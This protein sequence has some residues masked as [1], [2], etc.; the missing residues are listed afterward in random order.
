[1]KN[2]ER[3]HHQCMGGGC[4]QCLSSQIVCR[5]RS[6]SEEQNSVPGVG[7]EMLAKHRV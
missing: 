5:M 6:G 2:G 7:E 1:M 4:V 3:Q